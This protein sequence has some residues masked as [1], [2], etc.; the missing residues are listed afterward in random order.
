MLFIAGNFVVVK[1]K[2][3]NYTSCSEW[4]IKPVCIQFNFN[5]I[6]LHCA[7][8]EIKQ[9]FAVKVQL[10]VSF[11]NWFCQLIHTVTHMLSIH[12]CLIWNCFSV[13]YI[14]TDQAREA[15]ITF[16]SE[17]CCYGQQAA[18]DMDIVKVSPS[19][20]LHVSDVSWMLAV[21][22]WFS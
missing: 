21:S 18:E 15:L 11:G 19:K 2:S 1:K 6:G 12:L 4:T 8:L 22:Y 17:S 9:H 14:D 16:V 7:V 10:H 20:A 3:Y 13:H 5:I